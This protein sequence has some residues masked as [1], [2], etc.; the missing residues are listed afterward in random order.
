MANLLRA[1]SLRGACT[2]AFYS[3]LHSRHSEGT[4]FLIFATSAR[5]HAQ[6]S[7]RSSVASALAA[8]C[9]TAWHICAW[10]HAGC[11][12]SFRWPACITLR[13]HVMPVKIMRQ[14]FLFAPR[15]RRICAARSAHQLALCGGMKDMRGRYISQTANKLGGCAQSAEPRRGLR[16]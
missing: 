6:T 2:A 1:L 9:V 5:H 8:L 4:G 7:R 14:S 11:V 15:G 13:S 3:H 12:A 10:P 16:R